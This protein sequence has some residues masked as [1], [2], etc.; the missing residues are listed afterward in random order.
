MAHV[1][2]G[3][4]VGEIKMM[5]AG[6]RFAVCGLVI[7]VNSMFAQ[8]RFT[9][10][11]TITDSS[12]GEQLASVNIRVVGTSFGTVTNSVGQYTLSVERG[13]R[14]I[15]FSSLGYQP[16]T[17]RVN[18]ALNLTHYVRLKESPIQIPEVVI[19]AEDPAIEIIRKAIANKRK[20]MD[21]LKSYRFEAFTRQTL[22]SD[23]SIASITEAYSTGYVQGEDTLRE[24]IKQ[25]R[26]TQN[27]PLAENFAAVHGIVNF[28]EDEIGLFRITVNDQSS[29]FRF[30][31]PT[32]PDALE[33][34]DYKLLGTSTVNRVEVYKIRMT[35]T[36]RLKPLFD[37]IIT[38]ADETF[39]VMGVDVVPNETFNIPFIKDIELRYRQQFSL[40]DSMFWMPSDIRITGSLSVSIIGISMPKIGIEQTSAIYDYAVNVQVPDSVLNK[41]WLM[42]DSS[43]SKFDSTFWKEHEILPLTNEEQIAYASLDSTQTL[44]KQFEPKGPLASLGDDGTG[45]VLRYVDS[46][47]NR[48]EGFFLGGKITHDSLLTNTS[49]RAS[50]GYGFSDTTFKYNLGATYFPST[51]K[52]LGIGVDVYRKLQNIPDGGYYGTLAISLMSLIDK[53]DYRDYFLATGW[54][55]FTTFN[56]RRTFSLHLGFVNENHRLMFNN[57]DFSLFSKNKIFRTN[58]SIDE[59]YLRSINVDVRYGEEEVPLGLVSRDAIDFSL[60]HSSPSFTGGDFHFTRYSTFLQWN[61]QTFATD[62][63]FPPKLSVKLSAGNSSGSLPL[64]KMFVLDSRASG[65]APFGVLRGSLIKEFTGDQFVMLNVEH[66]FRSVPFL[67]LNIPFLYKNN[68]ELIVHGSIAKTWLN[69]FPTFDGV[70]T[71]AGIGINRIF[72]IIRA[73]VTYRFFEPRRF[74]FT[75]SVANLF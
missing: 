62:L 27:I 9:L 23:T 57:T 74:Y 3:E 20:W 33:F 39:A 21:K 10:S 42:V 63:L 12:S 46:R 52:T 15:V 58:S 43:A 48:V 28:N 72:D 55:A 69:S 61:I 18:I 8:G 29:G 35:P 41:P 66:N 19:S 51:K 32:A 45:S 26:Q 59:G 22:R 70:Y 73:D 14:T 4:G 54:R 67:A 16:E 31:G 2:D 30:V 50:A 68:I 56:P 17:L 24:I 5:F 71:E 65:Y 37:G 75:V 53:N 13:N 60:E 38:I 47:F 1:Q 11:G 49:L 25:K 64:Q 6:L 7:F 44:E 34:Y 40:Y 36:T